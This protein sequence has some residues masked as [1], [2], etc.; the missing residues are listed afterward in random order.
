MIKDFFNGKYSLGITY[1]VGIFGIGIFIKLVNRAIINGFLTIESEAAYARLELFDLTFTIVLAVYLLL[2]MRALWKSGNDDRTLGGWGWIGLILTG[3]AA[4][5]AT[6]TAVSL[7]F[8]NLTQPRFLVLMEIKEFNKSLPADMG[9][10]VT[11]RRVKITQNDMVFVISVSGQFE[12]FGYSYLESAL[13]IDTVDGQEL[14][15]DFQGYFKGGIDRIVYEY[16]FEDDVVLSALDGTD[17]L[18]WLSER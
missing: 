11:M 10:G 5:V 2:M 1:W 15:E 13:E 6:Y 7:L 9:D 17:C 18:R 14:C 4:L 12:D 8:P 3:F 16:T